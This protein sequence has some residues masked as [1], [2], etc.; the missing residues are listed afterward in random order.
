MNPALPVPARVDASAK[1]VLITLI[2]EAM[3]AGFTRDWACEVLKLQPRRFLRWRHKISSVGLVDRRPG[4]VMNAITPTEIAAI[5]DA[6]E[7][8]GDKDFSHR[9]LAHRGSYENLFWVSPSTVGR[10]LTDHD[11]AFHH[12]PR[13]AK[14]QR[15]P[16]PGWASY[17]PNSIWIHDSTHFPRAGVSTLIIEDLVS[18]KW[19]GDV[20]SVE[21]TH[22]QVEVAFEAA[23]WEEG[24]YQDALTR[25]HL[26]GLSRPQSNGEDALTPLLLAVS[27]NGPQMRSLNTRAFMA[28]YAI[29][30]HFGRPATPT[31]QAWIE[32]LNGTIKTEWP[33]LMLI[34]DPAELR[35]E[36]AIVRQEY[37]H[38]RLHSA[39]GYVTPNDEHTGQGHQ[40]RQARKTGLQEAKKTRLAYHQE[41]RH[42]Q[43]KQQT[44]DVV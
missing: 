2:G 1:L 25:A 29:A 33:H 6:F 10:V 4:A 34:T 14:S 17:V 24:L 16:F 43:Q 12:P 23:L 36:L 7:V 22:T 31:D 44:P 15:R 18:R 5:L 39:I 9:R 3:D 26:L 19:V 11:L 21:E 30:Q 41:Q 40:I 27:D 32:S 13:P 42:N 37:N 28:M 8:F 20:T 35:A 38:E